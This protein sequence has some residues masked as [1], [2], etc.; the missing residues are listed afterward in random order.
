MASIKETL[1]SVCS[2]RAGP[3]SRDK[4]KLPKQHIRRQRARS[5]GT[6]PPH[7]DTYQHLLQLVNRVVA[8]ALPID[9]YDLITHVQGA[10]QQREKREN[11]GADKR[12]PPNPS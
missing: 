10:C 5:W 9:F 1:P 11:A 4:D 12:H 6:A 8:H 7:T 2:L 3:F